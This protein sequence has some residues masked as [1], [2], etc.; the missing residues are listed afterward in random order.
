[1]LAQ[2]EG[3][4]VW[5]III[6]SP[7][8]LNLPPLGIPF[9]CLIWDHDGRLTSTDRSAIIGALIDAGCRYFVCGGHNCEAWHNEV[10]AEYGRRHPNMEDDSFVMTSWH[11][12][13]SPQKVAFFLIHCTMLYG[14]PDV[15]DPFSKYLVVH[16]GSGESVHRLDTAL[17]KWATADVAE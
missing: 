6:D 7:N 1:M 5:A 12:G 16:V 11:E 13:E 3:R 14:Q 10:D 8:S 17:I 9:P 4:T 15:D 2:S